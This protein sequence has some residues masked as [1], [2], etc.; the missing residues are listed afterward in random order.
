MKVIALMLLLTLLAPCKIRNTPVSNPKNIVIP[1]GENKSILFITE[2]DSVIIQACQNPVVAVNDF[3]CIGPQV[4]IKKTI[5]EFKALLYNFLSISQDLKPDLLEKVTIYN[6][7]KKE[8]PQL[9]TEKDQLARKVQRIEAYLNYYPGQTAAE[10]ATFKARLEQLTTGAPSQKIKLYQ[11][12]VTYINQQVEKIIEHL[13]DEAL[14][15]YPKTPNGQDFA[16]H[17]LTR[18]ANIRN[19]P[20]IGRQ[21]KA[22]EK[23]SI[24]LDDLGANLGGIAVDSQDNFVLV[25]FDKVYS[26]KNGKIDAL[27]SSKYAGAGGIALDALDNW[28]AVVGGDVY[29]NSEKIMSSNSNNSGGIAV[30]KQGNWMAVIGD[31]V[32]RNGEKFLSTR[33]IGAGGITMDNAGNWMAIVGGDVYKNGKK[34]KGHEKT[35]SGGISM[36]SRGDWLGIVYGDVYLNGE[37]TYSSKKDNSGYTIIDDESNWMAV[38]SGDIVQNGEKIFSGAD[39][40]SGGIA[41]NQQGVVMALAGSQL[42][43][44]Q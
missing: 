19:I 29:K 32:F 42:Y 3:R 5:A 16:Y 34:L 37:K 15:L 43:R 31:S 25:V 28:Y 33:H 7:G 4:K 36:N 14:H 17:L 44:C 2:G 20:T 24:N 27:M 38:V 8:V 21:P 39:F 23:V 30:D 22:C 6:T 12:A 13:T 41:I 9:M 11:E 26:V 18:G 40:S 35:V 10:L 1:Q